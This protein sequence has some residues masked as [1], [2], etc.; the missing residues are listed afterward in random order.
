[1]EHPPFEFDFPTTR[2]VLD[3]LGVAGEW[4]VELEDVVETELTGP[5]GQP[6]SRADNVLRVRRPR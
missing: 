5:E 2:Q 4:E 1:M 6:G 3:S